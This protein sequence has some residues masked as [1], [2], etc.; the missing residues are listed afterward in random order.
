M[1]NGFWKTIA[2]CKNLSGPRTPPLPML[3][4]LSLSLS[5]LSSFYCSVSPSVSGFLCHL[6]R[7]L[8]K[9][10]KKTFFRYNNRYQRHR[11]YAINPNTTDTLYKS[12]DVYSLHSCSLLLSDFS[13]G[14]FLQESVWCFFH[15]FF[16]CVAYL[17]SCAHVWFCVCVNNTQTTLRV[18]TE[19]VPTGR[20]WCRWL[21]G[22]S[23]LSAR[24]P[25]SR[26]SSGEDSVQRPA[27][28]TLACQET[29][30]PAWSSG[31]RGRS[32]ARPTTAP[33]NGDSG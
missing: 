23:C 27:A 29:T 9:L 2:M 31:G 18:R 12:P 17:H 5:L 30:P 7:L 28:V 4:S 3:F 13:Q 20:S 6:R 1:K 19:S 24:S 32:R 26:G 10:F 8:I 25:S 33:M 21:V 14:C 15:T 16:S 11:L 22:W